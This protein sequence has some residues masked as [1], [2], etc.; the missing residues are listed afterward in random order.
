M[1]LAAGRM[2]GENTTGGGIGEK[3][4]STVHRFSYISFTRP[5]KEVPW[6]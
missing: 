5:C 4:I 3:D 2:V 6:E 1:S